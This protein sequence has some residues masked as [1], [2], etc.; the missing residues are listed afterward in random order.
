MRYVT[1]TSDGTVCLRF[2]SP[3]S[4]KSVSAGSDSKVSTLLTPGISLSLNDSGVVVTT[5]LP[6][7]LFKEWNLRHKR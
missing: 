1:L 2:Y 7:P 6:D 4:L 5:V 3:I